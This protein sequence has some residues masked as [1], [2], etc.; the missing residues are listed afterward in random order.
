MAKQKITLCFSEDYF[1][2]TA[3]GRRVK[4]PAGGVYQIE[5]KTAKE[6]IDIGI[7]FDVNQSIENIDDIEDEPGSLFD[8]PQKIEEQ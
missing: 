2:R 8:D 7:A 6:L 1:S 4:Y 5:K 3:K